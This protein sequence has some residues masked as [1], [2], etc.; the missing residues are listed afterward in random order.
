[1]LIIKN[2]KRI[3]QL[4]FPTAKLAIIEQTIL[5]CCVFICA[6]DC[7]NVP[8]IRKRLQRMLQC[9]PDYAAKLL[10]FIEI[11]VFYIAATI[12]P[13]AAQAAAVAGDAR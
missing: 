1:M 8:N 2:K 12:F 10:I 4:L 9:Y 11:S 5:F 7:G 6:N 13:A 3:I